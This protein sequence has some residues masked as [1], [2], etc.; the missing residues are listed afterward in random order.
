MRLSSTQNPF[1]KSVKRAASAGRP[2]ED[3]LLVAE[4]PHLLEEALRG[5]WRIEKV[6]CTIAAGERFERL[7]SQSKAEVIELPPHT[8]S[9]IAA[10]ETTQEVLTLLRPHAWSWS[11]L[12][13]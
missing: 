6:L 10:T 1:L 3:G 9:A 13:R 8:L 12:L 11:D 2:T 5:K 7:I 4:G